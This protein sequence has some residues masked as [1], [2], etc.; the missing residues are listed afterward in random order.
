[1]KYVADKVRSIDFLGEPPRPT[2]GKKD[3]HKTL[4]GS[5]FSAVVV[6]FST[7]CTI[8]FFNQYWDTSSPSISTVTSIGNLTHSIDLKR[9]KFYIFFVPS[10]GQM[11]AFG[12]WKSWMTVWAQ[13]SEKIFEKDADGNVIKPNFTFHKLK[14]T[15]CSG[16]EAHYKF[17]LNMGKTGELLFERGSCLVPEDEDSYKLY[18]S[19]F[20]DQGKLEIFVSPCSLPDTLQ[21][22]PAALV[23]RMWFNIFFPNT[24]FDLSQ[25]F[26]FTSQIPSSDQQFYLN[27]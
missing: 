10:I 2:I 15:S 9:E 14:L 19:I 13:V 3:S 16:Y 5:L 17:I 25:K 1:M 22:K 7:V 26:N 27:T 8:I 18:G 21:C 23:N 24:N 20:E 4:L 12:D 6:V 11:D